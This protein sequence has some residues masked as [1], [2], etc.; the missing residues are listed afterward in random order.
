MKH[1]LLLVTCLVTLAPLQAAPSSSF[2]PKIKKAAETSKPRQKAKSSQDAQPGPG[3]KADKQWVLNQLSTVQRRRQNLAKDHYGALMLHSITLNLGAAINPFPLSLEEF[4]AIQEQIATDLA[5]AQLLFEVN[6]QSLQTIENEAEPYWRTWRKRPGS[7][8]SLKKPSYTDVLSNKTHIFLWEA[9]GHHVPEIT[10]T[11]AELVEAVHNANPGKR[12]L[13]AMEPFFVLEKLEYGM[14]RTNQLVYFSDEEKPSHLLWSGPLYN[15][16]GEKIH[17][18]GIDILALDDY[19]LVLTPSGFAAILGDEYIPW[20]PSTVGKVLLSDFAQFKAE[21]SMSPF[22]VHQRNK[23]WA[24][25]I[26]AI[27]PA[28]DIVIVLAGTGH[29][30]LKKMLNFPKDNTSID[31]WIDTLSLQGDAE[32]IN[33]QHDTVLYGKEEATHIMEERNKMGEIFSTPAAPR[34]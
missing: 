12:V 18:L 25:Y 1:I 33:L 30:D 20:L 22:G 7:F 26:K 27:A 10:A 8:F 6:N 9:G 32:K 14:T 23:Q 16:L 29:H 28:Y 2:A 19:S 24:D 13:F 31:I 5:T 34:R 11:T 4:I 17:R 3:S 15:R 21:I